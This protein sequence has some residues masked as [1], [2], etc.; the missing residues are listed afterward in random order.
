MRT[1]WNPEKQCFEAICSYKRAAKRSRPKRRKPPAG[2]KGRG[3][4]YKGENNLDYKGKRS[5]MNVLIPDDLLIALK[6][7]HRSVCENISFNDYMSKVVEA[8]LQSLELAYDY[9]DPDLDTYI[10]SLQYV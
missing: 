6:R 1:R 3:W 4:N 10:E 2:Q 8:H 9:S 7:H 5:Q